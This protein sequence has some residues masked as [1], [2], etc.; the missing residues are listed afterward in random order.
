M[1]SSES[2][3]FVDVHVHPPTKEF[4][5][6]A[7]GIHAEAAAKKFG[8]PIKL[9]TFEEM[10]EEY[11]VCG[12]EKLVMFAWDA[13]TTSHRPAVSNEFVSKAVDRYPDRILGFAS[14][15]PHK[16]QAVKEL[17]HSIRE[18]KLS[19]LKLHPQ[20]QAFEPND[21]KYYPIYSKC[22]ELNVPITFHTG[23]TNWGA[24]LK[25]GGNVKLRFSNPM[26]LDDVAADFPELQIIMAHPGWPWQDEQLAIA[27]HKENVYIDLS[28]WSPKYFQ[29][30]LVTYM[31]KMIPEKFMFGTDYPMLSPKRWLDDFG[32]LNVNSDVRRM[33]LSENARKLL[34]IK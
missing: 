6:D 16:K 31:T 8:H 4:L 26:L 23:S 19:G 3:G 21:P 33:V 12:V 18:L 24:G 17:D 20:V 27:A 14:V 15:D 32:G 5:I 22:L 34:R 10:L 30:L 1:P 29:P 13:E 25:G 7:G 9:A 11:S 2:N 28:G